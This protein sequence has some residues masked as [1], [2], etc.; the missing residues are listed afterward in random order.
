MT[1]SSLP[2]HWR[3]VGQAW[4]QE[5]EPRT[6]EWPAGGHTKSDSTKQVAGVNWT[7]GPSGVVHSY[8]PSKYRCLRHVARC[9]G[10]V[11]LVPDSFLPQVRIRDTWNEE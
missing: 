5:A 8:I 4:L 10:Y 3:P 9:T 7:D 11:R 1:L 6:G 2:L